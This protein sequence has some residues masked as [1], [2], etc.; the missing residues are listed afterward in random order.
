MFERDY[1]DI[2]CAYR[3]SVIRVLSSELCN[4]SSSW[5]PGDDSIATEPERLMVQTESRPMIFPDSE[6]VVCSAKVV[7]S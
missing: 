2:S 3:A 7:L 4:Y 1:S 6:C 5:L